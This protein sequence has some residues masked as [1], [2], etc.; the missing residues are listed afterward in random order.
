MVSRKKNS[1]VFFCILITG[2][3]L[4]ALAAPASGADAGRHFLWRVTS[5]TG[6]AFILGSIHLAKPDLYPLPEVMETSFQQSDVLVVE[7]D[8]TAVDQGKL[9][10]WIQANG[11][12]G[13]DDNL[14]NHLSA[15]TLK[16]MRQQKINPMLISRTKPWLAAV[17]LQ[18]QKLQSLGFLEE[19]GLDRYFLKKAADNMPVRELEGMEAQLKIFTALS[20][21]NSEM[22]LYATLVDLENT[23]QYMNKII[24]SWRGGDADAFHNLY[25]KGLAEHPEFGPLMDIIVYGRNRTMRERIEAL[26]KTGQTCFVIV[27]AGHLVG[28]QGIINRLKEN[29]YKVEQM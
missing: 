18:T 1:L 3:A 7:A 12:Y 8:I 24:R 26:L 19:Y 13:A 22:F 14:Q 5:D 11:M 6:R 2:L 16:K 29:G 10:R 23:E 20:A 4:A 27:G 9:I 17:T 15:R 21:Q 28:P 25:F